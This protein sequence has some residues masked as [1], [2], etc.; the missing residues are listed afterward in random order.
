MTYI[1]REQIRDLF[2]NPQQAKE[3]GL[4]FSGIIGDGEFKEWW[5]NGQLY[6]HCFL[7]NSELNGE[8]KDWNIN[9]KLVKHA[10]YK[11]DKIIEDYLK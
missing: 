1:A 6:K 3:D 4:W 2:T 5:A 10:L 8:S 7:K 9:G 11:D